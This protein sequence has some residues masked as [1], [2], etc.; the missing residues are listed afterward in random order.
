[1][2]IANYKLNSVKNRLIITS[3][4]ILIIPSLCIGL[5]SYQSAKTELEN[6]MI[7]STKET[8]EMTN[9]TIDQ[10][11]APV[12]R[13]VD[14]LSSQITSSSVDKKDP[15]TR[16]LIEGFIAKHPELEL[17]TLGNQNGAWMKAPDPGPQNY[18]PRTRDWYIASMKNKGQV[19][20]SSPYV[21]ATTKNMVISVSKT[22]GDGNGMIAVNLDLSKLGA[23]LNQVKIGSRGYIYSLDQTSR[24]ISHPTV[25][26]GEEAIEDYYK[27][28]MN[29]DSGVISYDK[30]GQKKEGFFT[31]NKMT[32][33]KII[34]AI[35]VDEFSEA[36]QPILHKT[37]AVI[38]VALI[39]SG[40]LIFFMV[41]SIIMPLGLLRKGTSSIKDGD[42]TQRVQLHHKDEFGELAKDFNDMADSLQ[43]LVSEIGETSMQLASSSQEMTATIEQTEESAEH[44]T[45]AI[46]QIALAA[47]T[48]SQTTDE[49]AKAMEEM[50]VGIQR[51]AEAAGTIVD[52]V[53]KAKQ[54]VS[55]GSETIQQVKEQMSNIKISV[56][57]SSTIISDLSQSSHH[58]REM[59][60]VI[61]EI[62]SQTNLLSLNA[63]IEAAR[64][65]E[66]GKGF[67]VVAS[68]IRKLADQSKTSA[69]SINSVISEM[70][71]MIEKAGQVM[72]NKV[73]IEV[74]KGLLVT[75]KANQA[76]I[77]IARSANDTVSQIHDI[78]AIA[79]EMS[80]SSEQVASSVVEI[81]TMSL[82]S[83]GHTQNISAASEEQLASM[84]EIT[85]SSEELARMAE[86]MQKVVEKF[87][88]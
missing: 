69:D 81:S 75:E 27:D 63:A 39:A 9:N 64:A 68:E 86:K 26:P 59:N 82:A 25:K 71:A 61:T 85:S 24:Y 67:A 54:D 34:G 56:N 74:D 44:V 32:G 33:W 8:I 60:S 77:E 13:D 55:T 35:L 37:M 4:I 78:S 46:V 5:L 15:V 21:S 51:I 29:N 23:L 30:D 57:E 48:Q 79:E 88:V 31:T 12:M 36:S 38:A 20:I 80:A 87:T 41:R 76:F 66:G 58:I 7:A 42:L 22:F 10:Y 65:G 40:I 16:S 72:N 43:A 1:M 17:V 52:S 83:A 3:L 45:K 18:D 62:A 84:Q 70:L 47:E 73:T 28:V 49:T 14:L 50:A 19:N 6:K 53:L 2:K 11:I